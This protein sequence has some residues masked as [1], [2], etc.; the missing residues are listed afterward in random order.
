MIAEAFIASA[1]EDN[2][3]SISEILESHQTPE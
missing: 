2:S 1:I 3:M